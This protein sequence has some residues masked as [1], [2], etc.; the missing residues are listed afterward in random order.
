MQPIKALFIPTQV[1]GVTYWRMQS[2]CNAASRTRAFDGWLLWWQ[3]ELTENH[4]WQFDVMTAKYRAR[5]TGEIQAG[6]LKADVV[7]MG[8]VSSPA[9]LSTMQGI[10][11]CYGKPVV[12]EIDDNI[13]SCPLYNPAAGAY[14]PNNPVRGI[15][16]KQLR[17]S[18]AIITTTPYLKEIYSDFNDNVYVL[19]NSIDFDVWGKV[20]LRRTKGKIT[21]GWM[22]AANH[23]DDLLIIEPVMDALLAKYPR[24]EFVFGHGMHPKFRNKR[25]VRW[26]QEFAR[27]DHYPKA[28]GKMGFDIGIAPLVDNAFNRGKSNLRWLEYSSLGISTVASNVG[29]FAETIHDGSDGILCDTPD[30]FISAL[31]SL[32]LDSSKRKMMGQEAK[33]RVFRDFNMDETVKKYAEIFK[34]I[35]DRGQ[36]KRAVPAWKDSNYVQQAEAVI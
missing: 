29:H 25:G 20:Q 33:K 12:T 16:V 31:E 34:E 35:S 24:V 19:P 1:A 27:I 2:P 22:G 32:I 10:R 9:G 14:A 5:I 3:K 17:E 15:T 36:L 6:C 30:D 4:P 8:M 13:L 18:D 23:N 26:V 7:V 28:I 11:E 21:I